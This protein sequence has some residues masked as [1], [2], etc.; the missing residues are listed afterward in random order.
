MLV[1]GLKIGIKRREEMKQK[2]VIICV[3]GVL[4]LV[5]CILMYFF[6][7]N[8][9]ER[10]M[11]T[12]FDIE[13]T[14][15]EGEFYIVA[16]WDMVEEK[17]CRYVVVK[18]VY[19]TDQFKSMKITEIGEGAFAN[20]TIMEAVYIPSTIKKI[21]KNAFLGCTNLSEINYQGSEKEWKDTN[22]EN[23]NDVLK[24]AN[25]NFN[26]AIPNID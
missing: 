6:C 1:G 15:V 4:L 14:N 24:L 18:P 25:I 12:D 19:I 26:V 2:N 10:Y 17:T 13:Q 23:G 22:I 5:A 8:S 11:T 16:I 3:G 20:T 21:D 7:P 9:N